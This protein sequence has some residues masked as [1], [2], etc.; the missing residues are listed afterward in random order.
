VHEQIEHKVFV[1]LSSFISCRLREG[2]SSLDKDILP[3]S[4]LLYSG[5]VNGGGPSKG[6]SYSLSCFTVL[7]LDHLIDVFEF[8][9]DL[10]ENKPKFILQHFPVLPHLP[11][12]VFYAIQLLF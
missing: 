2:T 6:I 8:F 1:D 3:P 7:A 12:H 4:H 10:F 11:V 5:L 9:V